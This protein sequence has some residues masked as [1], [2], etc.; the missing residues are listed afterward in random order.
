M[1]H[2]RASILC[3]HMESHP[4]GPLTSCQ[5]IAHCSDSVDYFMQAS[6]ETAAHPADFCVVRKNLN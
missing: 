4:V 6:I 3:A 5:L 2:C 1:V